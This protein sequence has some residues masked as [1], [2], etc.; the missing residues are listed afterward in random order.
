[1]TGSEQGEVLFGM[2]G[3]VLICVGI[4]LFV[5]GWCATFIWAV[6]WW[7]FAPGALFVVLG[8]LGISLLFYGERKRD[9]S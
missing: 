9:A 5:I 2:G 4:A 1:M 7:F 3:L 8:V 6:Q